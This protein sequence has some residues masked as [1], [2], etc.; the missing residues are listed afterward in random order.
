M[1]SIH[2]SQSSLAP[3]GVTV[4]FQSSVVLIDM[5]VDKTDGGAMA[6][7]VGFLFTQ[8]GAFE[9]LD[10]LCDQCIPLL[11]S[12]V[13]AKSMGFNPPF[14]RAPPLRSRLILFVGSVASIASGSTRGTPAPEKSART[15]AATS[16]SRQ[17]EMLPPDAVKRALSPPPPSS[18]LLLL[19]TSSIV[20]RE[21]RRSSRT[22]YTSHPASRCFKMYSSD[23]Q[24]ESTKPRCNACG[25]CQVSPV[26]TCSTLS[27]GRWSFR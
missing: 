24:S 21:R 26:A 10:A 16:N 6:Y 17:V 2:L 23:V 4:H 11:I 3:I 15:T 27:L 13:S 18:S 14:Q 12:L 19:S 20:G 1:A 5:R 7:I 25:P 8:Y 9:T 22:K